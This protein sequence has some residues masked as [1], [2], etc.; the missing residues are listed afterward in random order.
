MRIKYFATQFFTILLISVIG[1]SAFLYVNPNACKYT[2]T[3]VSGTA[4]PFGHLC[5]GQLIF[6]EEFYKLNRKTWQHELTLGGGG[7]SIHIQFDMLNEAAHLSLRHTT[8]DLCHIASFRHRI[9]SFNGML[10]IRRIHMSKMANYSSVQHWP[11][12]KLARQLYKVLLL[13]LISKLNFNSNHRQML[14]LELVLGTFFRF[15]CL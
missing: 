3:T 13:K 8:I 15:V 6:Y 12:R 9:G 4:A 14:S 5:K 11:Q 10:T 1:C 7:V 2:P